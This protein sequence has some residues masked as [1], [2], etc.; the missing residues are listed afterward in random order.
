MK[1]RGIVHKH[2]GNG[3]KFGYP[4]ANIECPTDLEEGVFVGRTTLDGEPLPSFVFVGAAEP[5]GE[6]NK[7]LESHIFDFED[8]YLYGEEITVEI[9]DKI[10]DNKIFD[11][12]KELLEQM[13]RDETE[14]RRILANV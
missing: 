11:S 12:V 14:A 3:R 13:K 10:R 8:R 7:R 5:L 2:K 9:L 1:I 6:T 4:T